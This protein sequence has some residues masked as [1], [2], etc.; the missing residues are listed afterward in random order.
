MKIV[1]TGALG[2]IGS[3]VIRELPLLFPSASIIMIDDLSTQRYCSL[4]NLPP[5]ASHTFIQGDL[6]ELDLKS[7]FSG[8]DVVIHLAAITNATTSFE[9]QEEVEHVNFMTSLNVAEACITTNT[10]MFL[11]SSTSVY[12]TQKK[13]VDENC[14]PDELKPQSPYAAT[15]LKEETMVQQKVAEEGLRGI[16]LR[17]GTIFGTSPGM[18]FHTAINK[19]CWQAVMG[20]PI[21]VWKS[22]YDQKR[23]Y[24]D[25]S[26][27]IRCIIFCLEKD[28]FNGLVYNVATLNATVKEVVNSIKIF[29]PTL[30]IEF[31]DSKIM[32]QLSYE[33][34][35]TRLT[36]KDFVFQ[37]NLK[38]GIKNTIS[39]LK[40]SSPHKSKTLDSQ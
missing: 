10:K 1:V 7:L 13:Q 2:H 32:N 36:E 9:N 39:L 28:L 12:G 40:E 11:I 30:E 26:D 5:Q 22:A 29:V 33:V 34:L 3:R 15:K 35:N 4:F 37:G 14:S 25:L 19:F 38:Q 20:I 18:R 16:I 8:I 17:L 31:V 24:L 21:T 6:L 23:P 27:A